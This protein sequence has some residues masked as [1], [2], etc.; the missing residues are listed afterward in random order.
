MK[1]WRISS[2]EEKFPPH[3]S[4][5][6]IGFISIVA[7]TSPVTSIPVKLIKQ[8]DILSEGLHICLEVTR[9]PG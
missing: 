5:K 1:G 3:A 9:F 4:N 7:I 8:L 2:G 6:S